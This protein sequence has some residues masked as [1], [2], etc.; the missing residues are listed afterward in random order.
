M[1]VPPFAVPTRLL[2]SIRVSFQTKMNEKRPEP[3]KSARSQSLVVTP[4]KAANTPEIRKVRKVTYRM[5]LPNPDPCMVVRPHLRHMS[6]AGISGS[7]FAPYP[8]YPYALML[9]LRVLQ[10]VCGILTTLIGST[11]CIEEKS[12][13]TLSIGLVCGFLTLLAAVVSISLFKK[14]FCR[15]LPPSSWI[16]PERSETLREDLIVAILWLASVASCVMMIGFAGLALTAHNRN[17]FV[18]GVLETIFGFV[19]L[20]SVVGTVLLRVRYGIIS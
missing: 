10:V 1:I 12:R 9:R 16:I 4:L 3:I 11:A 18:L 15:S 19:I 20:F 7:A 17:V 2:A 5:S 13:F 8:G 14:E 6:D